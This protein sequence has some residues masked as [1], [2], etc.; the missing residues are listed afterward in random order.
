MQGPAWKKNWCPKAPPPAPKKKKNMGLKVPALNLNYLSRKK[1]SS[2]TSDF[3]LG[4]SIVDSTTTVNLSIKTVF[5]E[6]AEWHWGC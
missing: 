5:V 6:Q 1:N 3:Y 4:L 2:F